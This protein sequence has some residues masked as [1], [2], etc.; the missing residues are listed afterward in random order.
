[1]SL[2]REFT[3]WLEPDRTDVPEGCV[4]VERVAVAGADPKIVHRFTPRLEQYWLDPRR[5]F[6]V[7]KRILTGVEAPESE[8]HA[9]GI[10]KHVETT[11][12]DFLP[13][14]DGVWYPTTVRTTGT[15][16]IKQINPSIVQPF[17]QHWLLTVDFRDS[18]PG[19]T[20]HIN[21]AQERS[22]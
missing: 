22:P 5:N 4:L 17:D 6:A 21:A 9:K 20:F 7:V 3:R 13:S 14:P 15:V 1:M 16:W 18:F 19:E 10:A 8:C 2:R 11:F 12:E